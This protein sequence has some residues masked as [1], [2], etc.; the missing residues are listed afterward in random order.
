MRG[1]ASPAGDRRLPRA[2]G[3]DAF[4]PRRILPAMTGAALRPA[5]GSCPSCHADRHPLET[6]PAAAGRRSG[7][8]EL[9]LRAMG[10]DR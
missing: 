1:S 6:C 9:E 8:S 3:P 5:D 10:G 7:A 4:G 2:S